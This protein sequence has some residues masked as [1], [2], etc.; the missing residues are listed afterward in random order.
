M[1]HRLA[2]AATVLLAVL[3]A[4]RSPAQEPPGLADAVASGD[5]PPVQAR[6]PEKPRQDVPQRDGWVEGRYGGSIKTLTRT[7]RD[8]RDLVL[9][10]Y[11]RLMTWEPDAEGRYRLVPDILEKVDVEAG[12]VFTLHLRPGHRWSDGAP[13]TTEDFRFWWEDI[14]DYQVLSPSG[15]PPALLADGHAPKVE[16]LDPLR[17]RYTWTVANSAFLPALAAAEPPFVYRPAH[18]LKQFHIRYQDPEALAQAAE[19]AGQPSWAALFERMDQPYRF[20]NPDRPSLQPWVNTTKP[21]AERYIGKRNP[22]FHRVDTQGRQLPYLDEV[23]VERSQAKLIPAQAASGDVGLQA[24]GLSAADFTLLKDAETR[25]RIKV[26]LW[27]I[28]R[29]AQLALYPNLNAADERWRNLLRKP[30]FRRALS[31]AIDREA[32][33]QAL[34]QGLAS[35]GGNTVLPVSPLA[36][37][38]HRQRW[39]SHDPELAGALLDDLGLLQIEPDAP[40]QGPDGEP[41]SFVVESGGADPLEV[42]VLTLIAEQ[43]RAIGV[44]AVVRAT[45]RQAFRQRVRSGETVMSIFYGLANGVATPEMSPAE[46]APTD[47]RQNNWP[48]WGRYHE[49]GALEGLEPDLPEAK[50]LLQLYKTW[51]QA[52]DQKTKTEAWQDMLAIHAEQVFTIGLL[53]EVQQPIVSDARLRNLPD[54]GYYLFEPG[55]YLGAYRPDTF[56]LE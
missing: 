40:R 20:A 21:P 2:L 53:A 39:A 15:P 28:G 52:K 33:N 54:Q 35:A 29:G 22:Y 16:V 37:C 10:G 47:D 48:L 25:G 1:F 45:G 36:C 50:Q 30:K 9:L 26:R 55:A 44:E 32:I 38:D 13:F 56:W 41:L 42:D 43:W 7:G 46:L 27:P 19:E 49:S 4:D 11:A 3:I 24:R 34:Y 12:R 23:I 18:Y 5:L 14:A 31:L 8:P 17:I 51:N 6:L